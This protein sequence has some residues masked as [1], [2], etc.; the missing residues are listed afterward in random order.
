MFF[1]KRKRRPLSYVRKASVKKTGFASF[2]KVVCEA[3]VI[4]TLFRSCAFDNFHVP[5]GSMKPTLLVGDKLT[6]SKYTYGY[7]KYSFPFALIP[8]NGRFFEKEPQRGD[9]IVFKLPSDGKT[10][11]VKRLIG[12]PGDR[13]KMTSG[14]LFINGEEVKKE[15]I[16]DFEDTLENGD[17]VT[18][19]QYI[20][21]LPNGVKHT[22]L[23]YYDGSFQDTTEEY[24]VPEDC[25]FFMGDNRDSSQDSRFPQ[26]GFVHKEYILGKVRLIIISSP[27][28][29]LN[30][31]K[32]GEI[33]FDRTLQ[34]VNK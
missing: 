21:T 12:L 25:Y 7:S 3:L 17:K 33:K 2:L 31:F 11:Y 10:N 26:V 1:T 28:T 5:S 20:E 15:K 8:F 14:V 9:V 32:W 6:I 23:D 18:V 27:E 4:A 30:P 13:I 29:L 34:N 16:E 19:S 22:T 24:I